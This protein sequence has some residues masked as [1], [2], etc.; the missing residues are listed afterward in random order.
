ME[1]KA[2]SLKQMDKSSLL[3]SF[4]NTQEVSH[5]YVI[6]AVMGSSMATQKLLESPVGCCLSPASAPSQQLLC[7]AAESIRD[8]PALVLAS[9]TFRNFQRT[10]IYFVLCVCLSQ[11]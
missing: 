7:A 5:P 11:E 6:P 1:K 4:A 9:H 3:M 2:D 10:T 8:L